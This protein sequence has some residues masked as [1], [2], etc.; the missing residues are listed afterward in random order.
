MRKTRKIG[1][2]AASTSRLSVPLLETCMR[3][4]GHVCCLQFCVLFEV[5]VCDQKVCLKFFPR[6]LLVSSV[7]RAKSI[8][9]LPELR[10]VSIDMQRWPGSSPGFRPLFDVN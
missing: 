9:R 5:L 7:A 8:C 10:P 4:L 6:R 2:Y 3:L 1:F